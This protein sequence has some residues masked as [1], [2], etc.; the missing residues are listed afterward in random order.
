MPTLDATVGGASANAYTDVAAA[1]VYFDERLNSAAWTAANADD[2]ARALIQATR[3]VDQEQFDGV[4]VDPPTDSEA[5]QSTQTQALKWPRQAAENDADWTYD[6]DQ[7]PI[8]IR[9]ATME[10]ALS[11]LT[12]D[13]DLLADSGLEAFE[14]VV[15]GPLEV[16]PRH[17]QQAG[18]LPENVRRLLRPVL[19]TSPASVQLLRA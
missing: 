15:V 7:I 16:T 11:Y 17:S 1:D 19:T 10:L 18:E 4:P 3:R 9:Q 13:G 12:A 14:K 6:D 5:S 8:I 2:K